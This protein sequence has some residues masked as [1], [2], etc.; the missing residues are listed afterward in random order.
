MILAGLTGV[1]VAGV[2]AARGQEATCLGGNPE[3]QMSYEVRKSG[4]KVFGFRGALSGLQ[5]GWA[6]V[7]GAAKVDDEGRRSYSRTI[8]FFVNYKEIEP[9][10]NVSYQ[11]AAQGDPPLQSATSSRP[12]KTSTWP[13]KPDP[14]SRRILYWRRLHRHREGRLVENLPHAAAARD[15]GAGTVRVELKTGGGEV[16]SI[17]FDPPCEVTADRARR[18][19]GRHGWLQMK[20]EPIVGQVV[21][22]VVGAA[23]WRSR[24][25]H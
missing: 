15:W 1:G 2:P 9:K 21:C 6:R 11:A 8:P 20:G 25:E 18:A 12:R 5:L 3:G 4:T 22:R 24:A 14:R 19:G 7:E 17:A 23:A 10:L 13:A 16:A